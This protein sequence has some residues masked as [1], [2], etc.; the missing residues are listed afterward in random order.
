MVEAR[1]GGSDGRSRFR[2]VANGHEAFALA[3][4]WRNASQLDEWKDIS[5]LLR[6]PPKRDDQG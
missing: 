3:A 5:A 6:H 1:R 4:L 2:E